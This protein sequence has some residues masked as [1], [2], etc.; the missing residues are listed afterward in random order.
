MRGRKLM[1]HRG[2]KLMSHRGRKSHIKVWARK[3]YSAVFMSCL[4]FAFPIPAQTSVH[5]KILLLEKFRSFTTDPL[6]LHL[7]MIQIHRN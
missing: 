4:D 5:S 1:S 6:I 2:R 7:G 3:Y